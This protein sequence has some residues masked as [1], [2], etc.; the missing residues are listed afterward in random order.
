MCQQRICYHFEQSE[1]IRKL[2]QKVSHLPEHFLC[3]FLDS[4][5]TA[6]CMVSLNSPP[7]FAV[8]ALTPCTPAPYAAVTNGRAISAASAPIAS[9]FKDIRSCPDPAVHKNLHPAIHCLHN[10]RKNFGCRR[11]LI[12][13]SSSVVRHH[14][15]LCTGS[16]A[17]F[18]PLTVMIPFRIN[19]ISAIFTISFNSSTDLLP[20]RRIQILKKRKPGRINIHCNSKSP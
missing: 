20:R 14:N 12:Q 4:K 11:T 1:S 2:S 6:H 15:R 19:G 16:R 8:Y 18:A 3:N 17:F 13:Y 9:R 10:I 7:V 5:C